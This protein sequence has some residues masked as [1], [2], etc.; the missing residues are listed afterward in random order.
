MGGMRTFKPSTIVPALVTAALLAGCSASSLC[1]RTSQC[2]NDPIPTPADRDT[3]K[4][5]LAANMNSACYNEVVAT[6]NCG[7]D[8]VI[9]GSDGKTD[10]A[11]SATKITNN[12]TMQV[13][14]RNSCCQKNPTATACTALGSVVGGGAS[15]P[16][17]FVSPCLN[18]PKKTAADVSS[19]KSQLA[20]TAGAACYNEALAYV[21]CF[22]NG[23][24]CGTD[25]KTDATA[26]Q[27]KCTTQANAVVSCCQ[28][29]TSS[30]V[31]K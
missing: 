30:A 20:S 13:V 2:K 21:G 3:C 28:A 6:A 16:C 23:I 8:N 4:N 11:L 24:V 19:C 22:D 27:N 17:D 5:T 26:T 25:G 12:C 18:D 14:A 29:N 1:D 9:C 7:E 10:G 31:C 15:S